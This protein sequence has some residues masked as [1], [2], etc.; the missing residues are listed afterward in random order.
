[1]T[2]AMLLAPL[3][4][5]I[6]CAACAQTPAPDDAMSSPQDGV[7]SEPDRQL[8]SGACDVDGLSGFVGQ[9]GTQELAAQALGISGA[10]TVRWRKPGM[11]MT[12]DYRTDRL[13]IDLDKQNVV[14]G[15]K[16]G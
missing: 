3:S 2:R 11:A 7:R 10:R 8:G 15:F 9:T 6:A 16:C 14:T 4:A 1:M 13:N 12:M 5:L